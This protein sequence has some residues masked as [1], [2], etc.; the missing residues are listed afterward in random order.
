MVTSNIG[1]IVNWCAKLWYLPT[2]IIFITIY[3]SDR[4]SPSKIILLSVR[5]YLAYKISYCEIE[6]S[7]LITQP[8]TYTPLLEHRANKK[9][10]APVSFSWRMDKTYINAMLS[11]IEIL[12]IRYLNNIVEQSYCRVKGKKNQALGWKFDE[13]TKATLTSVEL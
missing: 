13:G 12:S 6:V 9:K 10:E 3:F 4:Y 11:L 7:I 1:F 5:Y 2:L 8:W